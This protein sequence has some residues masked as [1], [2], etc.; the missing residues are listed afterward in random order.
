M[1]EVPAIGPDCQ[2]TYQT[3]TKELPQLILSHNNARMR[4][5]CNSHRNTALNLEK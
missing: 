2:G 1:P 5:L 4:D 3:E